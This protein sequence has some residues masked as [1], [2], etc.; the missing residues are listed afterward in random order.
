M[1]LQN[2]NAWDKLCCGD[3]YVVR[4]AGESQKR[5]QF[6]KVIE[7]LLQIFKA[8]CLVLG[9]GEKRNLRKSM[10]AWLSFGLLASITTPF[11]V[12]Q[13]NKGLLIV[14]LSRIVSCCASK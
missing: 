14:M 5:A 1:V 9:I 2:V 8:G 6:H 12:S 11:L 10:R 3:R 7:H 13:K 4:Y